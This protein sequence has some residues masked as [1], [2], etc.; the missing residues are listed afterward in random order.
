M[1]RARDRASRAIAA[2]GVDP[3]SVVNSL[4]AF[5]LVVVDRAQLDMRCVADDVND[6]LAIETRPAPEPT[7]EQQLEATL[8]A[9]GV[10]WVALLGLPDTDTE[11]RRL[12]MQALGEA[13]KHARKL[14][15]T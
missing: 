4:E 9:A 13:L 11:R 1:T 3:E 12:M 10:V 2:Y 5:G 14:V 15:K 8:D 7:R 6:T